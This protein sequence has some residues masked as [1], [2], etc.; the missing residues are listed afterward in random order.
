MYLFSFHSILSDPKEQNYFTRHPQI[1]L[2]ILLSSLSPHR[3]D[4]HPILLLQCVLINIHPGLCNYLLK[5][6]LFISCSLIVMLHLTYSLSLIIK[7]QITI[8]YSMYI[9][10]HAILWDGSSSDLSQLGAVV[11]VSWI[12][13]YWLQKAFSCYIKD[14][15]LP[16]N[17]IILVL[18]CKLIFLILNRLYLPKEIKL[19]FTMSTKISYCLCEENNNVN[20]HPSSS[21]FLKS[22]T[23]LSISIVLITFW[24]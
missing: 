23:T 17:L 18:L 5:W 9:I 14:K 4:I 12:T 19:Y 8:L 7:I 22:V 13:T 24:H 20:L 11:N 2:Y 16:S 21:V 1:S 6:W 10:I 15:L 3:C